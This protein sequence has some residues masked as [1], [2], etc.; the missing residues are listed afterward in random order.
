M[1]ILD[2]LNRIAD[3][4][5]E[6]RRSF[7]IA[8]IVPGSSVRVRICGV[9]Q[10]F[11]LKTRFEGWAVLRWQRGRM[12][13]VR[14]AP[15]ELV[16]KYAAAMPRAAFVLTTESEGLQLSAGTLGLQTSGQ[17]PIRLIPK[18]LQFSSVVAG[19]DGCNFW[20]IS[21]DKRPPKIAQHL[22][23]C[24]AAEVRDLTL[25][26][27]LP[28]ERQAYEMALLAL[29]PLSAY[30]DDGRLTERQRIELALKQGNANLE[31]Y[32]VQN[33]HAAQVI[34]NDA[35]ER[36]T[37]TINRQSL[38][39]ISAGFCLSGKDKDFDLTSIVGV[40]SERDR[41]ED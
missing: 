29:K 32:S 22:R 27:L 31:S 18:P 4:E 11:P 26:G 39:V 33:Q 20:Y 8:P 19:F 13:Y 24:L 14:E 6:A 30:D 40:F 15:R 5:E 36:R 10:E 34:F 7:F 35:G 41:R 12:Q 21:A 1:S 16:E 37:V 28:A 25:K 9:L 17:V 23:N 2:R 3:A 38:A